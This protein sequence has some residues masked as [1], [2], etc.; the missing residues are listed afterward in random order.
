MSVIDPE[1]RAELLPQYCV[2]LLERGLREL[3]R[4]DLAAAGELIGL[5]W[6]AALRLPREDT[7]G[8]LPLAML[9]RALL[10]DRRGNPIEC[11]Q[12][13]AQALPLVDAMGAEKE[14]APFLHMLASV[15]ADL[16]EHRRAAALYDRAV[17][18][19]APLRKP[20]VVAELLGKEGVCYM[21]CG[22]KEH[23]ALVL[24]AA[25]KIL[26]EYPGE[27]LLPG[28]L[29]SLGNALRKSAPEEAEQL[30][31]EAA[32]IY[33][34]KAQL[35]SAAAPW[36]NLGILCSEQGRHEESL[37]YYARV[38]KVREGRAGV[39]PARVA[40]V[41]NNMACA[42]RR[43]GDVEEALRLVDRAL[44]V[45]KVDD[46]GLTASMYGTRGQ[47]LHDA[48]RDG[49]AV[50]WLRKSAEQRRKMGSPN[51]EALEENLGFE[52]ACLQRL[53]RVRE[54]V[55]AEAERERIR[56][57]LNEAPRAGVELGELKPEVEGAVL[58]ELAFGD[59]PGGRY[60]Q[61]D[62]KVVAQ[63]VGALVAERGAGS[64]AGRVTIPESVTLLFHGQDAE[65]LWAAM[66][67]YVGDHSI[68][69][70]ATVTLRQGKTT[71]Q[72]VMGQRVN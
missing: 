70:G 71:R 9:C 8:L 24:R 1:H 26:R 6:K 39:A 10:E 58:I 13:R 19:V 34:G 53:G 22:L 35:E 51:L 18:R 37:A 63:Q 21:R 25:V 38:L 54:A 4:K 60:G 32:G 43:M 45:S 36:V 7:E 66:Q 15:L 68:F 42:R 44:A 11:A 3:R 67:Q 47:I 65:A 33:E 59:R 50:E 28:V 61:E 16:G 46:A 64:Y 55:E 20:L 41:L 5:A 31:K 48:R 30:F 56:E 52:I 29:I 57:S 23:A 14:D 62:A 69:D 2:V 12:V 72:L 17:E 40:S 27:P 49:E